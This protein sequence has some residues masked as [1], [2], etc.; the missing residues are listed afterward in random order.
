[1]AGVTDAGSHAGTFACVPVSLDLSKTYGMAHRPC[2]SQVHLR[3][4]ISG[5]AGLLVLAVVSGTAT[6]CGHTGRHLG[7]LR[8]LLRACQG[9]QESR[10][11]GKERWLG[12][13]SG[14]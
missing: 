1:M 4:R 12:K 9:G 8:L 11:G 6:K 14:I 2:S 10:Q 5:L 13:T 7:G 3:S